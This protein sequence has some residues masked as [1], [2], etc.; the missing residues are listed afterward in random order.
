MEKSKRIRV[1]LDFSEEALE[2]LN[3]M[4]ERIAVPHQAEVVRRALSLF[5]LFLN[6]K[7]DGYSLHY[8]KDNEYQEI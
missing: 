5:R 2:A 4:K 7:D 3:D 1:S 6:K 8:K